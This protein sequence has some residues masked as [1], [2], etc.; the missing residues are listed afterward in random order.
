MKKMTAKVR[1]RYTKLIII[2]ILGLEFIKTYETVI[3]DFNFGK[4][5]EEKMLSSLG[6]EIVL[7]L[8]QN[9]CSFLQ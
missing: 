4:I 8:F 3:I 1:L 6:E 7:Y 2:Y 9:F 5:N